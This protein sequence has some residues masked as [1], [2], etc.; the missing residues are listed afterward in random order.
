MNQN[1]LM[2][3]R[4]AYTLAE[5][6]VAGS[7]SVV[8]AAMMLALMVSVGRWYKSF[9]PK[10][11]YAGAAR[12]V[13]TH[14][15]RNFVGAAFYEIYQA[16]PSDDMMLAKRASTSWGTDAS[17]NRPESGNMLVIVNMAWADPDGRPI[18]VP[19]RGVARVRGYFIDDSDRAAPVMRFFDSG[20]PYARKQLS[21]VE[22]AVA[23]PMVRWQQRFNPTAFPMPDYAR[24]GMLALLPDAALKRSFP[25][26]AKVDPGLLTNS[27]YAYATN[28]RDPRTQQIKYQAFYPNASSVLVSIPFRYGNTS[29]AFVAPMATTLTLRK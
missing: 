11:E 12:L 15:R 28:L 3:A 23:S 13:E 10:E 1:R 26:V 21:D 6:M 9:E 19:T 27:D 20:D 17:A 16:Y 22:L 8:S 5:V 14:F 29:E 4:R 7:L 25:V 24:D 2:R 18:A